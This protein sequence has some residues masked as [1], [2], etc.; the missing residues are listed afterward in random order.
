MQ[1]NVLNE[2]FIVVLAP[3]LGSLAA[4]L[5]GR[6]IGRQGAHWATISAV[7]ISF[8][9]SLLIAKQML[10]DKSI[11]ALIDMT[12]YTWASVGTLH[13]QVGFL[14]DPLTVLMM[15]VVSFVSW[16]VH[17]YTIGYMQDDP[18][19]LTTLFW[20]GSGGCRFVFINRILV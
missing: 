11:P 18:G 15:V 9:G 1:L 16:M 4:G 8:F 13:F 10:W 7:G 14:L 3:L 6:V 19:Y 17:I 5:F 2:C 20:L 12:A